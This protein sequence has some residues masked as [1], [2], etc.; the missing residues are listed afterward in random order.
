M[1]TA[2]A[3]QEER[4]TRVVAERLLYRWGLYV[5]VN[6]VEYLGIYKINPVE[7][8]R[9]GSGVRAQQIIIDDMP[10]EVRFIN[11]QVSVMPTKLRLVAECK[12]RDGLKDKA[13]AQKLNKMP[14]EQ[15]RVSKLMVIERVDAVLSSL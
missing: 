6:R 8:A 4:T 9:V 14:I 1:R 12:W 7:R 10:D 15:Y 2:S 11:D 3:H 5:R 13:G